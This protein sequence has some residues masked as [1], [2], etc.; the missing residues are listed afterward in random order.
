MPGAMSLQSLAAS[1]GLCPFREQGCVLLP[2]TLRVL[3]PFPSSQHS[4]FLPQASCHVHT[5]R[6]L[7]STYFFF[8]QSSFSTAFSLH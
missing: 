3:Q 4:L 2:L 6:L 8:N 1:P 7:L 5:S